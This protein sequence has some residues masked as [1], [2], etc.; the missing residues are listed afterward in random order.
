M[1][2]NPAAAIAAALVVLIALLAIIGPALSPYTYDGLDWSHIA[3]PPQLAEGHW[4]GTDRLGRDL[5]V[6]TLHGVRVSLAI[7]LLA[8]AVSLAIGVLWGALAGYL[9]GR[10]DEV[11]MRIVDVLYSLPYIFIVII[12]MTVLTRGNIYALFVAIGAVGWLTMARIVR[13]Q[14]LS[15]KHREFV[16]AAV[17][18]GVST[19]GILAR[20]IVPNLLGPVIVYAALTI[21]QMILYESF[22]SFLG[23]GVQE[24][25]A[26]LGSLINSGARELESAPWM[27]IVPAG[28]LVVLLV[29]LNFVGDALRDAFDPRE[30]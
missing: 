19:P 1:R 15:L 9:G 13:G 20:H 22:L 16:E 23:L 28:F 12:L 10:T 17:V 14:T 29:A 7:G 21:P 25:L 5:F 30:R 26:S 6:R 11:M 24:P 18:A 8:T 3:A 27:L 4:L 2:R